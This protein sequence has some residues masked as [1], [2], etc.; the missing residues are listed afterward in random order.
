MEISTITTRYDATEDRILLAVAD[1]DDNQASLWLTRR[2][3][4]RLIPALVENV[5]QQIALPS[6]AKTEGKGEVLAAANVYAQLQARIS[7]KPAPAVVLQPA[8]PQHLIN[9]IGVRSVGIGARLLEFRC[10]DQQVTTLTLSL[11]EQRQWL[12]SLQKACTKANWALTVWPD[13][14]SPS[15]PK[16]RT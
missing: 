8:A 6:A 7:K 5:Q 2:L 3:T 1:A 4:E 16:K 13:W 9:E 12:E 10:V 15:A 14:L 11:T